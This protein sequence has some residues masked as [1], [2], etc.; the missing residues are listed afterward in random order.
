MRCARDLWLSTL[1]G[2]AAGAPPPT[3]STL[4]ALVLG[5]ARRSSVTAATAQHGRAGR[6]LTG[7]GPGRALRLCSS[8]RR[9]V[10]Q[11]TCTRGAIS[12]NR[13][14]A[15]RAIPR[16]HR[17]HA[18]A[19][20]RRAWPRLRPSQRPLAVLPRQ[21]DGAGRFTLGPMGGRGARGGSRCE[22][23]RATVRVYWS[24]MQ[25]TGYARAATR[26]T[27]LEVDIQSVPP[28]PG[29]RGVEHFDP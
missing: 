3:S 15:E 13:R 11:L 5:S 16:A 7:I 26:L 6:R 28:R 27:Y 25:E 2:R 1:L 19:A 10:R 17:G 20:P 4:L 8:S 22:C 23:D 21:P 24:K 29:T 12:A 14:D 18:A 9:T